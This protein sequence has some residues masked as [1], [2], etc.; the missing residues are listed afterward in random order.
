MYK[1]V[2]I[3]VGDLMCW[4]TGFKNKYTKNHAHIIFENIPHREYI[5]NCSLLF[6]S[7]TKGMATC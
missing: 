1:K 4:D 5:L 6:S 7:G 2:G 3:L